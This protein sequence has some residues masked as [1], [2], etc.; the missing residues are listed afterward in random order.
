MTIERARTGI[1]GLD[2]LLDGGIPRGASVVIAGGA[3][4]GKSITAMQYIYNG[5]TLFKEPGVFVTIQTNKQNLVWDMENFNWDLKELQDKGLLKIERLKFMP[6]EDMPNQV[7]EQ[8]TV[9]AKLVK[10]INAKRLVIDS[11]S[12]LGIWFPEKGQLRNT[13]FRFLDALKEIGCTT[14]LT[15]E[16]QGKMN[17][18]GT[19]SVEQYVADGVIALYFVPPNRSVFVRKMRGTNHSKRI[20]PMEIT[21]QGIAIKPK[22][23]VM[24]QSLR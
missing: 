12:A 5:A 14:I 7:L 18:F 17:Q 6:A 22:D 16:T 21:S 10:S 1:P 15:A 4:C 3:G 13:L 19:F 24:W 2:E 9:I 23:E 11:I 8:L 20:H